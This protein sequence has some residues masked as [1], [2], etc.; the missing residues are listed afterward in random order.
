MEDGGGGGS[1]IRGGVLI[2]RGALIRGRIT[3]TVSL[4]KT[5]DVDA[6]NSKCGI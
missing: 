6:A 2:W 1:Q 5:E 4:T 3:V